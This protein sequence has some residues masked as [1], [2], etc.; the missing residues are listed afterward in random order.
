MPRLRRLRS[1]FEPRASV[2]T[3]GPPFATCFLTAP[4]PRQETVRSPGPGTI[5]RSWTLE[6]LD[7]LASAAATFPGDSKLDDPAPGRVGAGGPAPR[8]VSPWHPD[9]AAG[10]GGI[11]AFSRAS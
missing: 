5:T 8:Q 3:S 2:M 11:T 4:M 6:L 9:E 1:A 7:V 10:G